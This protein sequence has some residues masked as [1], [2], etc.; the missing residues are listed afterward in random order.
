V[1]GFDWGKLR[2]YNLWILVSSLLLLFIQRAGLPVTAQAW[3]TLISGFLGLLVLVGLLNSPAASAAQMAIHFMRYPGN[4]ST[5]VYFQWSALLNYA[6]LVALIAYIPQALSFF[7]ISIDIVFFNQTALY[8]LAILGALG[9]VVGM[10]SN[11]L[12]L[13]YNKLAGG[14]ASGGV[15]QGQVEHVDLPEFDRVEFDAA[16]IK[17]GT[18]QP[19]IPFK[20]QRS[21]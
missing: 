3:N 10:P 11:P 9:L 13:Q 8:V 17:T 12:P 2:N 15:I 16:A 1:G 6:F 4:R 14:L 19:E 18:L 5:Q 7:G 21:G 20:P